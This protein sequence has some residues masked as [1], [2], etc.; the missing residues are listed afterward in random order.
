M[1]TALCTKCLLECEPTIVAK[2]ET[3]PVR[4]EAV[5]VDTRV[6]V[7][8]TCG[9]D[10]SVES[11]DEEAL[12]AAFAAYRERHWL[13]SPKEMK[14]I[15]AQY[16]LGQRAFALLLGWGELTLHRYE[17][18]SLQDS[19]HDAQLRMAA[20]PANVRVLLEANGQK[21]SEQQ[22]AT[23]R[24]RL[25]ELEGIEEPASAVW[26]LPSVQPREQV[27][28]FGGY[29]RFDP[30]KLA[31]MIVFF[32]AIPG[33]FKTKMN[34]MLFYAD[35][36]HFKEHA[37]S[38][39]GSPYLAFA[40]GPVP[41]HYDRLTAALVESGDLGVEE[42]G[43]KTWTGEVLVAQRQADL[44]AF[45][46]SERNALESVAVRLRR[47]TSASISELSHR[48]EAYSRTSPGQMISYRY[49]QSLSLGS[50]GRS[51]AGC[52]RARSNVLPH[53]SKATR[54]VPS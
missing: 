46:D 41:E 37:L 16:D 10:V 34:K 7:C 2:K 27:D 51:S 1:E 17:S 14:S 54:L 13:L 8:P 36:L 22:R 45:S 53:G 35:F 33:M 5:E 30:R 11:L 42:K 15:R 29:R 50:K 31:E 6:G 43:G 21:L 3:F 39:S 25:D 12:A 9:E 40:R 32:G 26:C 49:A 38:I 4:G 28:E 23:L 24:L 52:A 47:S 20:K 18:G 19:A 44:A 48:E